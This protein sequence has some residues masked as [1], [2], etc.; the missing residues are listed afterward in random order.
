MRSCSLAAKRTCSK[1]RAALDDNSFSRSRA[2]SQ[3]ATFGLA[4]VSAVFMVALYSG[5]GQQ[6]SSHA[7]R[8]IA[9]VMA[10]N[11]AG[12]KE[13]FRTVDCAGSRSTNRRASFKRTALRYNYPKR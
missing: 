11:R 3:I 13:A 6:K 12:G 10:D 2:R 4:M 8:N 9:S 7:D 5:A 1:A